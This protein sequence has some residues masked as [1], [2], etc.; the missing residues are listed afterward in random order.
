[1]SIYVY[2][3]CKHVYI[4]IYRGVCMCILVYVCICIGINMGVF[5][6]YVLQLYADPFGEIRTR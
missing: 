6:S 1:V 3:K 4:C 5:D 2:I